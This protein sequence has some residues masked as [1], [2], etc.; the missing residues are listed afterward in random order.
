MACV[1]F[2]CDLVSI[3]GRGTGK[4]KVGFAVLDLAGHSALAGARARGA[5]PE[6]VKGIQGTLTALGAPTELAVRW[7]AVA[8]E[9][10]AGLEAASAA[11]AQSPQAKPSLRRRLNSA[12]DVVEAMVAAAHDAWEASKHW[13]RAL[14]K[15]PNLKH[16]ADPKTNELAAALALASFASILCALLAPFFP[17]EASVI[18]MVS[19]AIIFLAV[20]RAEPSAKPL[21]PAFLVGASA[22][23]TTLV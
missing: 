9:F 3:Y 5:S 15:D 23:L 11:K 21:T 4:N 19:V 12:A 16:V 18:S 13:A 22:A 14:E 8:A 17:R 2:R 20:Q 7:Y 1:L 6:T 10:Y